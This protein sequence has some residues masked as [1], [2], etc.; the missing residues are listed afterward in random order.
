MVVDVYLIHLPNLEPHGG[1][2]WYR[3]EQS[4]P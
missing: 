3:T 4:A 2:L 1:L